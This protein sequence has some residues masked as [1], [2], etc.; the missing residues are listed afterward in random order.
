VLA[1]DTERDFFMSA[2]EAKVY[3]LVDE[4]LVKRAPEK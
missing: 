2:D 1:N 3:G 4:V